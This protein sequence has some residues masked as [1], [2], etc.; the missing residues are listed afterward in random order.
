MKRVCA[1]LVCAG[2]AFAWAAVETYRIDPA[3]THPG[4]EISHLG[5]STQRGRFDHTTG[6]IA[7]DREAG[8]GSVAIEID[9]TSISTGTPLLD[10]ALRGEDFF[11]VARYPRL[12]FHSER[13]VFDHGVPAR[14]P[15]ELTLL[16]VTRPVELFINRFACTRKPF[17][18]RTTCGADVTATISRS[19]FGMTSYATF[20]GDEVR[21]VIQIE[22]VKEEPAPAPSTFSPGG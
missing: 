1:A 2:C 15:G 6:N 7:V 5:I 11:D 22:A 8:T 16:G 21:L 12:S 19:D 13:I 3:H 4:F 9:A 20:I 18:V 14:A 17:L 10:A